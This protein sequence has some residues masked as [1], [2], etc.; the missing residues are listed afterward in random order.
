MFKLKNSEESLKMFSFF[1]FSGSYKNVVTILGLFIVIVS[2]L[3][4][5]F[6]FSPKYPEK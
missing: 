6:F 4:V 5:L 3:S 2:V 1:E